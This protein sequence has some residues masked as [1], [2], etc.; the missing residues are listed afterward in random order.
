M[1]S[2][3]ERR[4]GVESGQ[5]QSAIQ[6][7]GAMERM[8]S[9][10][11]DDAIAKE[12]DSE[13]IEY[14]RQQ[15]TVIRAALADPQ[16]S[17]PMAQRILDN[18]EA[19]NKTSEVPGV[20][21]ETKT[22]GSFFM[23]PLDEQIRET[24]LDMRNDPDLASGLGSAAKLGIAVSPIPLSLKSGQKVYDFLNDEYKGFIGIKPVQQP[25]GGLGPVAG[26]ANAAALAR[27]PMP[28]PATQPP[29]LGGPLANPGMD[30]NPGLRRILEILGGYQI[31]G[32]LY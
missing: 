12:A 26:A 22:P 18:I 9:S 1:A 20:E 30:Q 25:Q 15:L 10:A 24:A 31:P 23:R 2:E 29:S 27:H 11:V 3:K 28:R 4:E 14:L 8:F 5:R 17:D 13:D 16:L 19:R 21:Q 32:A 7:L 6:H